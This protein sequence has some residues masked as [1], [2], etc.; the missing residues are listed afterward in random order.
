[1]GTLW[2]IYDVTVISPLALVPFRWFPLCFYNT[3]ADSRHSAP[4]LVK[5]CY[6]CWFIFKNK[7]IDLSTEV[8]KSALCSSIFKCIW[9]LEAGGEGMTEDKMIGWHHW[10]NGQEFEQAPGDG[11]GQGG[12]VYCSSWVA[13]NQK[14]MSNWTTNQAVNSVDT[15]I[16]DFPAS[17]TVR[18]IFVCLFNH[19]V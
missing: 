12:L 5:M 3:G 18:N 7:I 1:M 9:R 16:L 17:R 8:K 10:L 6:C 14:W 11:E 15:L 4:S 2:W 13:M 19:S